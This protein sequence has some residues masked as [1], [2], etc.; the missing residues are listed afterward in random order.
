MDHLILPGR[1]QYFLQPTN[2][3]P[4]WESVRVC[5]FQALICTSSRFA[6]T[7]QPP[8]QPIGACVST[9]KRKKVRGKVGGIPF[10]FFFWDLFPPPY[11]SKLKMYSRKDTKPIY[12]HWSKKQEARGLT[13]SLPGTG[14]PLSFSNV[15]SWRAKPHAKRLWQIFPADET[16]ERENGEAREKDDKASADV[17]Q[18]GGRPPFWCVKPASFTWR[19]ERDSGEALSAAPTGEHIR[20][21]ATA[22]V[23]EKLFTQKKVGIRT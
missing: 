4:R 1:R 12:F 18:R 22:A 8:T 7:K 23:R 15:S 21:A 9:Q 13:P 20:D 3:T 19:L 16:A 10:I 14:S 5:A 6:G 17:T 11:K 2:Q